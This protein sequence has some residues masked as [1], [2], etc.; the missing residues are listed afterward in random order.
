MSAPKYPD[1]KVLVVS[2]Q[3][4]DEL[5]SFQ[6]FNPEAHRYLPSFLEKENNYF[7]ERDDAEDDPSHKQIIPYAIFHHQGRL[8]HYV[9]GGASGE[10]RLA[11]K[12][13]IGIGGHINAEDEEASSLEQDTY[14]T[15]VEREVDE[16]LNIDSHNTQSIVGLINDD[17]TE[18]GSVHLGVVHL[19]DLASDTVT[20]NED[21]IV[22][23]EFL[24]REEL[25]ARHDQLETW[26]QILVEN[27]NT[28]LP[29]R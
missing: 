24:T 7:L 16:E 4:F 13:S 9:R 11:S 15:G 3:L 27:L 29:S 14:M 23:L 18:V 28:I 21:N 26:S 25:T 19:F 12:G 22:D 17:S 2:R 10:K 1:E 5:G 8:L 6:G 20:S